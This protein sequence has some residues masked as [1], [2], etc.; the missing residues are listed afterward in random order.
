MKEMMNIYEKVKHLYEKQY[1][2][3]FCKVDEIDKVVSFIDSYWQKNHIFTKSRELL[4]WQH[5]D[6][7]NQRYNFVI[8][9]HKGTGEIHA[10]IGFIMSSIYDAAIRTPVRWGAIWKVR[11]D[12]SEKGLGVVLKGFMETYAYAP[13]VAGIGLSH[14]S[15]EINAKLGEEVGQLSL[16]YMLN[17]GMKEYSLAGAYEDVH[18]PKTEKSAEECGFQ[19]IS[20]DE[21]IGGDKIYFQSIPPFKSPQYYVGRY[22]EHPIYRYHFTEMINEKGEADACLVWRFCSAGSARCIVVADYLGSGAELPGH[23]YNFQKLLSE[24]DAEYISFFNLGMKEQYFKEA[25]F[26]NINESDIIIPVYYEPFLKKNVILDY[27]YYADEGVPDGKI[28]FK[29]DADQDRPNRLMERDV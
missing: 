3:H 20:K 24:N 15:K 14:Y 28:F 16:F 9:V 27:H 18:F 10:L 1:D 7:V 22:F 19:T 8:A 29:G 26:Q 11:E 6:K 5:Y 13:Y 4:D 23:Y 25:G 2:I 12:V 17:A 21:F